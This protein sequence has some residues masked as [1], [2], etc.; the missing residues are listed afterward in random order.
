MSRYLLAVDGGN[1]ST[2]A[3]VVDRFGQIV[4]A[5]RG[6]CSDIYGAATPDEAIAE[7]IGTASAAM[8]LAGTKADELAVAVFSLAGADWPEDFEL[9]EDRLAAAIPIKPP[10]LVVNDAIGALWAGT[11]D[12]Q[13]AAAACGTYA[14]IAAAGPAGAWHSSFWVEPAG[15]VPLAE[16][17]LR[18]VCRAELGTGDG[19]LLRDRML[20]AGGFE[21]VEAL[22]HNFTSRQRPPRADIARFAPTVFDVADEGDPVARELIRGQGKAIARTVR[23]GVARAELTPPYPLVLAGG[24]FRHPSRLLTDALCQCVPDSHPCVTQV[25]PAVGVALM[26]AEHAGFSDRR[27]VTLA[28]CADEMQIPAWREVSSSLNPAYPV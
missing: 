12:G 24:L 16:S 27:D 25:E 23:A 11:G 15:A 7:I 26:A 9:L 17:A 2:V 18:A 5:A 14:A 21:N 19:T 4:G 3:L 6:S 20:I 13:G 1:T 28:A 22:L 10:P 8:T